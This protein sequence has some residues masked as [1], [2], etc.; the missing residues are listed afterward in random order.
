MHS[1]NQEVVDLFS[2]QVHLCKSCLKKLLMV[3]RVS[4][5]VYSISYILFLSFI[6]LIRSKF[7]ESDQYVEAFQ[8]YLESVLMISVFLALS[9]IFLHFAFALTFLIKNKV[10]SREGYQEL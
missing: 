8:R 4:V 7:C 5:F 1:E 3:I 2:F 9:D 6:L 10:Y